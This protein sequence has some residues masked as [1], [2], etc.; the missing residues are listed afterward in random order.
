MTGPRFGGID[1]ARGLAMLLVCF[2]HFLLAITYATGGRFQPGIMLTIT[3]A[4]SPAFMIISGVTFGYLI[5]RSQREPR[6]MQWWVINRAAL[7]LVPVHLLLLAAR[8][9]G[10]DS[11]AKALPVIEITDAI[12]LVMLLNLLLVQIE[13][14]ARR[15][16]LA[17]VMFV[18]AWGLNVAWHPEVRLLVALK[19]VLVR[20]AWDGESI[21]H[22]FPLLPWAALHLA[23][24]VVGQRLNDSSQAVSSSP[25]GR[26]TARMGVWALLSGVAMKAAEVWI[27]KALVLNESTRFGAFISLMAS[28]FGKYPPSIAYFFCWGGT[29]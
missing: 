3:V 29:G 13:S 16:A 22:G 17:A 26:L 2:A 8:I 19:D 14:G 12:A 1:K 21:L 25:I 18:S 4:A 20:A 9:T 7:L 24:S 23:A 28:P 6:R 10:G 27:R 11:L 15:L 5:A